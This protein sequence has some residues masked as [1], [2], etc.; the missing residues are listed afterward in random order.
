M[1]LSQR[2]VRWPSFTP[3]AN[4]PIFGLYDIQLGRGIVGGPLLSVEDVAGTRRASPFAFCT[5]NRRA[6]Q[7]GPARPGTPTY[8]WRELQRWGISEARLP[9]GSIVQFRQPSVWDQ[10]RRYI[11]GSASRSSGCKAR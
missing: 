5:A 7:D 9:A 3:V 1:L 8:D 6:H 4:A 2:N 11:V 10:Y